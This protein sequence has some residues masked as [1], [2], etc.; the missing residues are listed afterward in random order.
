M[1]NPK[2]NYN[3]HHIIHASYNW[4]TA[5]APKQE[6][7]VRKQNK[8]PKK[9]IFAGGTYKSIEK[10]VAHWFACAKK[11]QH[12]ARVVCRT[13]HLPTRGSR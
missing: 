10:K 5:S 3:C 9:T 13:L 11:G 4:E 1:F 8:F 6:T 12:D 7:A 2:P